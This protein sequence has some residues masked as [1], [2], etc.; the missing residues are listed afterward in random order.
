MEYKGKIMIRKGNVN[1]SPHVVYVSHK[2]SFDYWVC[3][4]VNTEDSVFSKNED[5]IEFNYKL[6]MQMLYKW[7]I[8]NVNRSKIRFKELLAEWNK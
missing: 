5:L 7:K 2:N 6:Y 8:Q 3:E 4:V 1:H